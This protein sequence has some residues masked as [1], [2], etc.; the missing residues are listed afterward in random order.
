M[1]ESFSFC[2][3]KVW[4]SPVGFVAEVWAGAGGGEIVPL[5]YLHWAGAV[6]GHVHFTRGPCSLAV[7]ERKL[8]ELP[9]PFLVVKV[10][11][12][13]GVISGLSPSV[14]ILCFPRGF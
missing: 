14:A 5:Q 8:F 11:C 3:S 10:T 7:L 9:K 6:D 1:Q 4:L 2:L 13:A 12:L